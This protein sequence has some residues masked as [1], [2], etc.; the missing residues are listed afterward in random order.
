ME[1]NWS[2]SSEGAAKRMLASSRAQPCFGASSSR[3]LRPSLRPE[4]CRAAGTG[5][6]ARW[7]PSSSV[8]FPGSHCD[9]RSD[10]QDHDPR[11]SGYSI[12]AGLVAPEVS[13]LP[14]DEDRVLGEVST[15]RA[16]HETI[17]HRWGRRGT[18]RCLSGSGHS[19]CPVWSRKRLPFRVGR[20]QPLADTRLQ[21]RT[22]RRAGRLP[23]A[24]RSSCRSPSR[25]T[26]SESSCPGAFERPRPAARIPAIPGL[27]GRRSVAPRRS[28][29]RRERSAS[30]TPA[31]TDR[32]G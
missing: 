1:V 18:I 13:T 31:C 10:T 26:I 16:T 7:P 17:H 28:I 8:A 3:A 15:L 25:A 6:P 14:T 11:A 12:A 29:S 4:C 32:K 23:P 22:G 9:M 30:G 21:R 27:G 5:S 20:A 19:M 24:E 2:S